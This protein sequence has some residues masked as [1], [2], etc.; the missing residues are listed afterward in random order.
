LFFSAPHYSMLSC[1]LMIWLQLH[2]YFLH[3]IYHLIF[4]SILWQSY[5]PCSYWVPIIN[6][7]NQFYTFLFVK[8]LL[9]LLVTT[10][11]WEY[12][13]LNPCE[14]DLYYAHSH[15]DETFISHLHLLRVSFVIT[16]LHK[17]IYIFWVPYSN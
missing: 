4:S 6:L 8:M 10:K 3:N 12:R 5:V 2:S 7:H 16:L 1:L 14:H 13:K 15:W 17:K 9:A 11:Y